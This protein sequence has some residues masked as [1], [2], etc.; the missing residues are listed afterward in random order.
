MYG[1]QSAVFA[2]N[3]AGNWQN[4]VIN[5]AVKAWCVTYWVS[6]AGPFILL[7]NEISWLHRSPGSVAYLGFVSF[8]YAEQ[9]EERPYARRIIRESVV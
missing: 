4:L 1:R 5:G 2:D 9:A 3:D 8:R 6:A 7:Y